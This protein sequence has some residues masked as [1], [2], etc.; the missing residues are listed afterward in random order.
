GRRPPGIG[1]GVR[2]R[3]T[4]ATAG[5]VALEPL[6]PAPWITTCSLRSQIGHE[7]TFPIVWVRTSS[8][9]PQGQLNAWAVGRSSIWIGAAAALGGGAAGAGARAGPAELSL[10]TRSLSRTLPGGGLVTIMLFPQP[11]QR[12]VVAASAPDTE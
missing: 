8:R 12:G 5:S 2:G 1:V 7:V 11:G 4:G 9:S 6:R 10:T 3:G